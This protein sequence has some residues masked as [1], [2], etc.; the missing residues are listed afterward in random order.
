MDMR[1]KLRI[2]NTRHEYCISW[3]QNI[4]VVPKG[5]QQEYIVTWIPERNTVLWIT[6]TQY[7]KLVY[8]R[9]QD[10]MNI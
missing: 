9:Y 2:L 5:F 8:P 10:I 4:N 6:N 7:L 3:I 1:H